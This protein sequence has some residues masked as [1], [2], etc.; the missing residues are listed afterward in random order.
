MRE[1]EDDGRRSRF[2]LANSGE[3]G[4]L[5]GNSRVVPL[6]LQRR[7][8]EAS[9]RRS[10]CELWASRRRVSSSSWRATRSSADVCAA[11]TCSSRVR[12]RFCMP[13]MRCV[14]TRCS[15]SPRAIVSARRARRAA[16]ASTWARTCA[17]RS[18]TCCAVA[19]SWSAR[20]RSLSKCCFSRLWTPSSWLRYESASVRARSRSEMAAERDCSSRWMA[21]C[22][23][24]SN[25]AFSSSVLIRSRASM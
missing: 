11:T 15:A 12:N 16:L 22:V 18:S 23:F 13:A 2:A 20:S 3:S 9:R 21:S 5:G 10:S 25:T 24:S 19:C 6:P 4:D 17:A 1:W 14:L 7:A 8:P